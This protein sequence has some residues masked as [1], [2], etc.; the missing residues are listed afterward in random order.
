MPKRKKDNRKQIRLS[1]LS[2]IEHSIFNF[3]KFL[4][5]NEVEVATTS[6]IVSIRTVETV[7]PVDT[8]QTDHRE[9]DTDTDTGRTLAHLHRQT[10]VSVTIGIVTTVTGNTTVLVTSQTDR[11]GCIG[12]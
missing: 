2:H 1:F 6:L 4:T 3:L 12:T 11:F 7:S 9:E 8:H 10:G 5:D